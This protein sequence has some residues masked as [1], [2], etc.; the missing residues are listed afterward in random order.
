M[1]D[2]ISALI[3]QFRF[4]ASVGGLAESER[5][6]SHLY[7][8]PSEISL[9]QRTKFRYSKL[10]FL[11]VHYAFCTLVPLLLVVCFFPLLFLVTFVLV[12]RLNVCRFSTHGIGGQHIRIGTMKSAI[13]GPEV[14]EHH[15]CSRFEA[16]SSLHGIFDVITMLQDPIVKRKSQGI[17]YDCSTFHPNI[18]IT[19]MAKYCLSEKYAGF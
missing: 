15:I 17:I 16:K 4:S 5:R 12:I 1:L 9:S 19:I 14:Y 6:A 8:D 7:R 11:L 18:A 3:P 2:T 10:V 13:G